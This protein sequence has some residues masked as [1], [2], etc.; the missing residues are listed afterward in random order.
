MA[1]VPG[2]TTAF[3]PL[4]ASGFL[5]NVFDFWKI[6]AER[7]V[8]ESFCFMESSNLLPVSEYEVGQISDSA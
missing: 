6:I 2:L 8:A 4:T 3:S 7:S 5:V 1:V